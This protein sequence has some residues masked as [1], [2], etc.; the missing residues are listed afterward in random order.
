MQPSAGEGQ[1]LVGRANSERSNFVTSIPEFFDVHLPFG[2]G[3]SPRSEASSGLHAVSRKV[4]EYFV[5]DALCYHWQMALPGPH[6]GYL[7]IPYSFKAEMDGRLPQ[8]NERDVIHI[9]DLKL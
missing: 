4:A 2:V 8:P 9:V 6:S 7:T 1:Q 3:A 5:G